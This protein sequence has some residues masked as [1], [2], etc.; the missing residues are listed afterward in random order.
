M[1]TRY[2]VFAMLAAAAL[3]FR[4]EP[5][6]FLNFSRNGNV[7]WSGWLPVFF[8][9]GAL[10]RPS[11]VR[12]LL[13]MYAGIAVDVFV[14]APAVPNHYLLTLCLGAGVWAAAIGGVYRLG[15]LPT[16]EELIA[17]VAGPLRAAVAVFYLFTGVWKSN[18]GFV[19][20]TWSC[21]AASWARLVAQ[22]GFLPDGEGLRYG[23]M[24]FTLALEYI[25][26]VLLLVPTTRAAAATVFVLFHGVLALDLV[27]NYQNFS[28]AM[29]PALTLFLPDDAWDRAAERFPRLEVA[30]RYGQLNLLFGHLALLVVAW[31]SRL[32]M[33][34]F[35]VMPHQQVRWLVAVVC[36]WGL[37]GGFAMVA[38][39]SRASRAWVGGGAP[40]WLAVA[41]V[42][43]N[44]VSP[45]IGLKNRNSWQMYSNVRI[46][47][48]A[49]NHWFLPPSLDVFGLQRD[50]VEVLE[51]DDRELL[52][53]TRERG[54]QM[55]WWDFRVWLHE[56]PN[57]RVTYVR[58]GERYQIRSPSE[59][60]APPPW[61]LRKVVWFRPVGEA[62]ARQCQW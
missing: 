49:S 31:F 59:L 13:A 7:T 19:D 26:P 57:T 3:L 41:M 27:Q 46:E 53:E 34:S 4:W 30:L 21:G 12:W 29:V 55:T 10:V 47:A 2:R 62:V 54:L 25:G 23:V 56:H 38:W 44:G 51:S 8:A 61:L 6:I 28:W 15:R 36:F 9:L 11:D 33:P 52:L 24:A 32:T 22:F 16:G 20:P 39:A 48:H 37:F 40:G 14:T 1:S 17:D 18:T 45:L 50:L 5:G 60:P 58:G 35:T 43:L 42:L